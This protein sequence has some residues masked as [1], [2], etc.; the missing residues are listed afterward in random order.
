[1]ATLQ[2]GRGESPSVEWDGLAIELVP[3]RLVHVCS[4]TPRTYLAGPRIRTW[5]RLIGDVAGH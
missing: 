1:M 4:T 5:L 3:Y 2:P